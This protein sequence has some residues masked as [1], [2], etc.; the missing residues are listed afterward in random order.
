MG[1]A[2]M[3]SRGILAAAPIVYA[4]FVVGSL[5]INMTVFIVVACAGALLLVAL[6]VGLAVSGKKDRSDD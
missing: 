2:V 4:A 1:G 3:N 5:F 6:Y